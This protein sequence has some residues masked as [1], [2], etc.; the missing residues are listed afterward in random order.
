MRLDGFGLFVEDMAR[1]IRF[2]RDVLG[3]EIKETE[4]TS[5]VYLVK[6]GTLFLLYGRKDFEK[7]T[8][9]R[10]DYIKGLNG[11]FEMALYVDTFDEVDTAFKNAVKNADDALWGA[12]LY[13][14]W[15]YTLSPLLEEKGDGYPE[16]MKNEE[17]AKKS[18]ESFA[19]SYTELKHD[20]VLYAKQAIAEMGGG[21]I[22]A[23]DDRGYVEPEVEVWARFAALAQNT[24]EGLK[25][26]GIIS[27][28]DVYNLYVM[29]DLADQF[30]QIS[31]KELNGELLSD[32][33]YDLIRYYGGNLEHLWQAALADEGD[34]INVT[35][36]PAALVADI[37]TD[38][39]GSCL[40]VGTGNPS[41]TLVMV[42]FDG[43]YHICSGG[44][45]SF[46]QFEWP[47]SDRL[48]DSEWRQMMGLEQKSD[49]SYSYDTEIDHPE[50]TESYRFI[51]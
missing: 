46:Y 49:G 14:A 6:D 25:T 37:A 1:M 22:P 36:F 38:P 29:A 51:R 8:S 20:T 21:D 43:G 30:M 17:W 35:N 15:I 13:S 27:E 5:N 24:A 3:F 9:R 47:L 26:Y 23:W 32:E 40:E 7:M 12:S 16:F 19:G 42:Y 28:D 33:E 39:N 41:K 31:E 45:Y 48:T 11:H 50:W 10:Y 4:D 2:Y 44:M 34:S 18:I